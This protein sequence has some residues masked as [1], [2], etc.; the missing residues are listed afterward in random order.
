[1]VGL[2]IEPNFCRPPKGAFESQGG[3]HGEGAFSFHD[4][5]DAAGW[6][7]NVISNAVF[8][9]AKRNKEFLA[10]NFTRM[11]GSVYFH[12]RLMVIDDFD[13]IG[14]IRLPA[15]AD[16]PLVID[17]DGVLALPVALEGFQTVSRRDGEVVYFCNGMDLGELAQGDTLDVRWECPSFPFLKELGCYAAGEGTDHADG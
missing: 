17:T 16:T 4:L 9:Q 5:I 15:E 2:E 13:F 1:M 6:Y 14:P 3:V 8:R 11:D 12:K 10:E 7:T